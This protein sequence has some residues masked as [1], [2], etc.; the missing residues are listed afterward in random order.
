MGCATTTGPPASS[1]GTSRCSIS[2]RRDRSTTPGSMIRAAALAS[3]S[4]SA[5]SRSLSSASL[6]SPA[7]QKVP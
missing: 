3:T 4:M 7:A 1:S 5:R 2:L 6:V